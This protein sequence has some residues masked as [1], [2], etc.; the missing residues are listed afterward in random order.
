MEAIAERS[1][2][3]LKLL[4]EHSVRAKM[5]DALDACKLKQA[6]AEALDGYVVLHRKGFAEVVADFF[7]DELHRLEDKVREGTEDGED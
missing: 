5:A 2:Q 1:D 3:A 4:V 7:V 6:I